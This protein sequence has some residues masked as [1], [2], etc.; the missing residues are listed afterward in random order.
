[1][2]VPERH[3]QVGVT[4]Q[5]PNSV[6]I[7]SRH[8]ELRGEIMP[9]VMP[10]EIFDPRSFPKVFPGCIAVVHY[11]SCQGWGLG[12]KSRLTLQV[13]SRV[14]GISL[15]HFYLKKP[16]YDLQNIF[17]NLEIGKLPQVHTTDLLS[18]APCV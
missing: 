17:C 12:F 16:P 15:S 5:L 4:Q 13:I 10:T 18:Y 1:M 9:H 3:F 2:R 8:N 6:Q 7:D 14:Q 11:F